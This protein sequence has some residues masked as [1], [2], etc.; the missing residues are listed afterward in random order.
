MALEHTAPYT[1]QQNPTE[2]AN[3]T[4]KTMMAQYI[5]GDQRTWDDLLPELSLAINSSASDTTGFSP[6]FLV[7]GREPRLPGAL[8]DEV[9]PGMGEE[10]E[11][12]HDKSTRL[13][14]IFKVVQANTQRASQEQRRTYNL[15]RREWRPTLG[16]MVL[17]RQHHLSKASDGFAAKLAPKYDGPY[18]IVKFLSPNIVRLQTPQGRQGK[19]ASLMDLKEFHAVDD[20]EPAQTAPK[21]LQ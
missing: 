3:R 19:T 7:L 18:K 11:P 1:P 4:I 13:Q 5:E 6:A 14:E 16:T 9:T 21:T 17:L 20:D 15:R 2:R 12:A 10:A 8:Y